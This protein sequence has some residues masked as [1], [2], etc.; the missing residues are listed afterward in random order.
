MA[1]KSGS[2]FGNFA[3]SEVSAPNGV[4]PITTEFSRGSVPDSIYTVN[5][6]SAWSRWRRGY[7]LATATTHNNDYSF[8]FVYEIPDA[9]TSGNPTPVISGAFVGYPTMSKELGMHWALWRYAGSTRCDKLTD[10]VSSQNLFIE[11]VT[12]DANYW[13]V[14]LAGTWSTSNPLPSPFYIPVPGEPD[15]LKPANTEI[16]EDRILEVDGTL[17]TKDTINPQTQKRYGYVQAVVIAIDQ[18]TGILTFKKAGSVQVTPDGEYITP[19]PISFTPGR[20]LASGSRY[21]CTCQDFTRRDYSFLSSATGNNKKQFPRTGLSNIKPGRFELT[22][23]DGILDNSAMAR[24]GQD[25]SL[26]VISP[27]GFELDY[28]TTNDSVVGNNVARD[29]P[30][31]YREFGATY[32]R[33]TSDIATL[34]SRPEGLPTYEDYSSVTLNPDTDS[35]PQITIT[36][37]DDSWTPLLDELRY[38]KH[39]YALKFKDRVFPPEPSDFPVGIG[40][41]ADWEQELV[42]KSQKEQESLKEFMETK[43]ALSLMDVPPYN[44]QSPVLFPMVQ[45]LFNLATG[46]ILI[47]NFTMFDKDGRP[48]TP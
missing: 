6:E 31:V 46:R 36:A 8:P 1:K 33:S 10:P 17:I 38:C 43:R 37:V 21:A 19:S 24:A 5:R 15:G 42:A 27:D 3:Q 16:F 7:E 26:E 22:K 34:G 9:T 47:E 39:I 18:D 13:Y 29:N 41:M 20:Y 4:K 45:R 30:G 44:C 25:R 11:S 48:Y 35:I 12:E 23:R 28:Q 14:K 32:V 40:S 2:S